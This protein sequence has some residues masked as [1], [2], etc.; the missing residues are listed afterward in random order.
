MIRKGKDGVNISFQHY[1]EDGF[2][3]ESVILTDVG[4]TAKEQ[5]RRLL[6]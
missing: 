2:V 1:E 4:N 5:E 6:E 3:F